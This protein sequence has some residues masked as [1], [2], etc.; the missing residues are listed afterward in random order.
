MV[1]L[2]ILGVL[3]V[4]FGVMMKAA[5]GE[6]FLLALF[7]AYGVFMFFFPEIKK[8]QKKEKEARSAREAR[9]DRGAAARLSGVPTCPRCGSTAITV[10]KRG[11]KLGRGLFWGLALAF[12][13]FWLFVIPGALVGLA[14]GLTTG[15]IGSQTVLA[16]CIS[17]GCRYN[18]AV[19][20][21]ADKAGAWK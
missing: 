3:C 15:S 16:T 11:Y 12:V 8:A 5:T 13:G 4:L 17:C 20:R 9:E 18:P 19:I 10:S 1:W 2:R 21:F 6:T 7:S 14:V